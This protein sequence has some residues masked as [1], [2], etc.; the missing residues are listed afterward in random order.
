MKRLSVW[1]PW[2]LVGSSPWDWDEEDFPVS[3]ASMPPMNVV[4]KGEELEVKLQVPGFKKEDV[5][6]TVEDNKLI[7][8][9]EIKIDKK[10]EDKD[11]YYQREIRA[12][13]SFSRS[14][15]LPTQVEADKAN[16]EFKNGEL[17]ITLPKAAQAKPRTISIEG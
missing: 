12:K 3:T 11:K 4:D 15:S 1:N 16:A 13:R 6:I 5:K 2:S 9:G 8:S 14:C 7:I 10:E 17:T